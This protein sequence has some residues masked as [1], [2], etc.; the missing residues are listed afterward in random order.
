[1]ERKSGRM[2]LSLCIG[3]MIAAVY[4]ALTLVLAPLSYGSV[5]IRFSECLTLLP[6]LFPEAVPGLTV[7]CL[8]ANLFSPVGTV[9]IL[10][11]TLA[12]LLAALGTRYFR[13][14]LIVSALCPVLSN[15]LLVGIM[16]SSLYNLPL[17]ATV[18]SVSLGELAAVAVGLILMVSMGKRA[19]SF[20]KRL[21]YDP[22]PSDEKTEKGS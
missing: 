15:G 7:G 10:V 20:L 2:V 17:L 19:A 1:M 4:A 11:G 21:G 18:G 14:H 22:D 12:T 16:L 3:G 6:I 13:K 5:Q 9:D 8:L